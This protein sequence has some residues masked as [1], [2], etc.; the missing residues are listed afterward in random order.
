M[1]KAKADALSK[2]GPLIIVEGNNVVLIRMVSDQ[3]LKF[4]RRC[5]TR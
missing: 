3:K 1:V 4:C 2:A 5:I